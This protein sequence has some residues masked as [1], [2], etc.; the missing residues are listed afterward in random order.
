[1]ASPS[2]DLGP[3]LSLLSRTPV[4]ALCKAGQDVVTLSHNLTVGDT[5]RI[6][7]RHRI[8][9]APLVLEPDLEELSAE[10]PADLTPTFLGWLDIGDILRAYVESL[11]QSAASGALDA[12]LGSPR[13]LHTP[14]RSS[15]AS[16]GGTESPGR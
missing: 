15:F 16:G 6:M 4:S 7:A 1:M 2:I 11:R 8:L 9:S 13:G 3:A 14:R 5:L 12:S 10:G